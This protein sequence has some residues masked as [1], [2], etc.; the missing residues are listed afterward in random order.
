M[1]APKAGS[2]ASELLVDRELQPAEVSTLSS[3]R[4]FGSVTRS[5]FA[6]FGWEVCD[7]E[8][9][10]AA[11]SVVPRARGR[12]FLR[13]W[14]IDRCPNQLLLRA[15][16]PGRRSPGA[17]DTQTMISAIRAGHEAHRGALGRGIG[18]ADDQPRR[19]NDL[20]TLMGAFGRIP[21]R[22]PS[23]FHLLHHQGYGLPFAGHKDNH[24]PA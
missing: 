18:A 10:L 24:T 6:N 21:T 19:G 23:L 8:I 17:G 12:Q 4:G 16:V 22:S 1:P 15:G 5:C 20:P 7:P 3:A 11:R 13:R 2:R 14:W 9:R